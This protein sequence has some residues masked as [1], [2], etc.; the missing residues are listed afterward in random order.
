M[1]IL[2]NLMY[3]E[4][5]TIHGTNRLTYAELN[6]LDDNRVGLFVNRRIK[7]HEFFSENIG[8]D[9]E[10]EEI[11]GIVQFYA[12]LQIESSRL[13][14]TGAKVKVIKL[15][16]IEAF[17]ISSA[18]THLSNANMNALSKEILEEIAA[19]KIILDDDELTFTAAVDI[20]AK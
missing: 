18:D 7:L 14:D 3:V 4:I 17:L 9:R 10:I 20:Q 16:P 11:S 6:E 19:G 2:D 15:D 8:F 5:S 12:E 1:N 13:E